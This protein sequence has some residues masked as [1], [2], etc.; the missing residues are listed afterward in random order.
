VD[1]SVV[2]LHG[3]PFSEAIPAETL[4]HARRTGVFTVRGV[5][6]DHPNGDVELCSRV[7]GVPPR[8]TDPGLR[9]PSPGSGSGMWHGL[10]GFQRVRL[11]RGVVTHVVLAAVTGEGTFFDPR[12]SQRLPAV[13]LGAADRPTIQGRILTIPAVDIDFPGGQATLDAGQWSLRLA[14]HGGIP[15]SLRMDAPASWQVT[16][17]PG[18]IARADNVSLPL[19]EYVLYCALPG[20]REAGMELRLSVR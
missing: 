12:P 7:H 8:C 15:H 10:P 19:G 11:V 3:E 2:V 17:A 13:V 9:L 6:L 16:A 14:N 1:P 20:H 5:V 4:R 18:Q